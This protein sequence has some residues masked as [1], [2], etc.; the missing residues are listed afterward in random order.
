MSIRQERAGLRP[1]LKAPSLVSSH[2]YQSL[3]ALPPGCCLAVVSAHE[4]PSSKRV[5]IVALPGP[6]GSHVRRGYLHC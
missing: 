1:V 4:F 6:W 5:H 3:S 2:G